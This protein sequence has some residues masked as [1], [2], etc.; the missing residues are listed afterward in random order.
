MIHFKDFPGW[1][2][3]LLLS[4]L[5]PACAISVSFLL[6][7]GHVYVLRK[8]RAEDASEISMSFHNVFFVSVLPAGSFKVVNVDMYGRVKVF[9]VQCIFSLVYVDNNS[10]LEDICFSWLF[11]PFTMKTFKAKGE[12]KKIKRKSFLLAWIPLN[13]CEAHSRSSA[14]LRKQQ[15]KFI[16][17]L[18]EW[19]ITGKSNPETVPALNQTWRTSQDLG[20][21]INQE[22]SFFAPLRFVFT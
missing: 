9:V 20:H 13:F 3:W 4:P 19:P 5:K 14:H 1:L 6:F 21:T 15:I 17:F 11:L 7:K 10:T 18:D 8:K 22:K 16:H 12:R 2:L